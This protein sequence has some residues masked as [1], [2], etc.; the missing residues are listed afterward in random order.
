MKTLFYVSLFLAALASHTDGM[1]GII[2]MA[3][4]I[5]QLPLIAA[6]AQH[7]RFPVNTQFGRPS[8][9]L[10]NAQGHPDEFD[11]Y[12]DDA[13]VI[14]GGDDD[15]NDQGGRGRTPINSQ[16][17]RP[18]FR[19]PNAEGTPD[20]FDAFPAR[21]PNQDDDDDEAVVIGGRSADDDDE[22]DYVVVGEDPDDA[23]VLESKCFA[24]FWLRFNSKKII[25]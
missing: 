8:F 3:R 23:V 16:F 7:S 15:D 14:V 10:P 1:Y 25:F 2:R 21:K 20:E 5:I 22:V 6:R 17:G 4:T 18:S 9:K 19:L 24:T 12:A 13:V 11:P